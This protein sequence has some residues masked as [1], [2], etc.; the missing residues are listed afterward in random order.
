MA[1]FRLVLFPS[2]H[3]NPGAPQ[4]RSF[5]PSRNKFSYIPT[6]GDTSTPTMS[7]PM[8]MKRP[9]PIERQMLQQKIFVR[10][11]RGRATKARPPRNPYS[12]LRSC[13]NIIFGRTFPAGAR[14]VPN[15]PSS[16]QTQPSQMVSTLLRSG[17]LTSRCGADVASVS[18]AKA[19][20]V[21]AGTLHY[22]RHKHPSSLRIF[23][24]LRK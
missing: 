14:R 4:R 8:T 21:P 2:D 6:V 3:I 17:G 13:E 24:P 22:P 12:D 23:P 7:T 1:S 19:P 9:I 16:S 15:A 18:G 10:S 11:S 5:P 20:A